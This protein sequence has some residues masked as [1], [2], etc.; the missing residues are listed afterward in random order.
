MATTT[1]HIPVDI[2]RTY[3]VDLLT[4]QLTDYARKLVESSVMQKKPKRHY[5]HNTLC[6][7]F[8]NSHASTEELIEDYLHDKYKL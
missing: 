4:Q 7:M 8:E 2:P 6:G 5:R 3:R 1:I